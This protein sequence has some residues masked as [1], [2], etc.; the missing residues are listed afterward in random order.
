MTSK[1]CTPVSLCTRSVAAEVLVA[2]PDTRSGLSPNAFSTPTSAQFASR[3]LSDR[4][5]GYARLADLLAY[6]ARRG[7]PPLDPERAR[8]L[9]ETALA[10][11][12]SDA[13]GYDLKTR[14]KDLCGSP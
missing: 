13:A 4:A 6:G 10:R 14:L 5:A 1:A 11:P 7:D 2:G 3:K 9:L 12:V 8:M